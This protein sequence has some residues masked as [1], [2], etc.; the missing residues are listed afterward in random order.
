MRSEQSELAAHRL[1]PNN[2]REA[3]SP[4][5]APEIHPRKRIRLPS[6]LCKPSLR[7]YFDWEDSWNEDYA[8]RPALLD[9]F[10]GGGGAGM[11]YYLAGFRVVG[12]DIVSQ[13]H[14]PFE[15][16]QADALTYPLDG[17]DA[18]HASPPCQDSS[19]ASQQWRA[20]GKVYPRLIAA[21]RDLLISTGKPFV[22]ENVPGSPLLNPTKLNGAF[23]GMR[24]R[25]TRLFETSFEMPLIL[26]PKEERSGFRMGR[27]V[28][29]DSI[30]TPVG[31]FSGCAIA[32]KRMEINWMTQGELAQAIP[33]AY[34]EFIG[35]YLLEALEANMENG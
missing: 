16:Y 33:P 10:A 28:T 29:E 8:K 27:P 15:F 22:I 26:L 32:R 5:P 19:M 18:Y 2:E 4:P 7:T 30:I 13:P 24:I 1:Y 34:T 35:K 6:S 14:F 17:F 25:R 21:T 9:L 12:I 20:A 3:L 31:H 23:F 11:G